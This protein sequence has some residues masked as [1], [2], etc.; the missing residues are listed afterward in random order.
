MGWATVYT[1]QI[2]FKHGSIPVCCI[3]SAL[4]H[5]GICGGTHPCDLFHDAF[6]VTYLHHPHPREQTD[7]CENISFRRLRSRA[8]TTM[9]LQANGNLMNHLNRLNMYIDKAK[10]IQVALTCILFCAARILTAPRISCSSRAR[11]GNVI[12]CLL[13]E[14][15]LDAGNASIMLVPGGGFSNVDFKMAACGYNFGLYFFPLL[16]LTKK[17]QIICNV[18][19]W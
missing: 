16:L 14:R 7:V 6:D 13:R 17:S 8:V 9:H 10:F 11:I 3:T 12:Y 15:P 4:C 18:S 19:R 1:K 2:Q 5:Y